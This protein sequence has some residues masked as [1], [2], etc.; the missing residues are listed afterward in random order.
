MTRTR[1]TA[2]LAAALLVVGLLAAIPPAVAT[3]HGGAALAQDAEPTATENETDPR[4]GEQF[5]GVVGVQGAELDGELESRSFGHAVARAETDEERADVVASRLERNEQRLADLDA[6]QAALRERR[7]TGELGEAE[8][9]A[10]V[11]VT[12]ARA[13][14]VRQTTGQG[15]AVA[16]G[17]PDAVREE[18][19][20]DVEAIATLHARADELTGPEVRE[21]ARSIAGEDVGRPVAVTDERPER[22]HDAAGDGAGEDERSG[23]GATEDERSGEPGEDDRDQASDRGAED[24]EHRPAVTP[25]PAR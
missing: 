8:Y 13:E 6:R 24:G 9:R 10:R 4:P 19:G 3:A 12:V 1:P 2:V 21:I 16:E 23:G 20:I 15:A 25:T 14:A 7:D 17:L 5:A 11:A 22:D 18:R